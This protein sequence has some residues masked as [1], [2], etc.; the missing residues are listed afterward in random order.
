MEIKKE[1]LLR[2]YRKSDSGMKEMLRTLFPYVDFEKTTVHVIDRI[3]TF[4]DACRELG[5]K[6]P[7]VLQY[8]NNCNEEGCWNG[9]AATSDFAAYLKLRIICAAL[10]EGWRPNFNG[11]EYR[12]FPWFRLYTKKAYE[13][14]D[15]AGR[16]A[17]RA[18]DRPCGGALGGAAYAGEVDTS[19]SMSAAAGCRLALKTKDLA[20]YC[21]RQF[22]GIW[23]DYLFG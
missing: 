20:E 14:L 23:A 3:K 2:A 19:S 13:E 6:H 22:L 11:C 15:E 21:G 8:N 16:K 12:Y 1:D 4:E 17:C 10:N 7:L 18:V 5:D 9:N